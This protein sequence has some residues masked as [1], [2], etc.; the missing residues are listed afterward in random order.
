[1]P[2]RQ[3]AGSGTSARLPALMRGATRSTAMYAAANGHSARCA[4]AWVNHR[5]GSLY[6]AVAHASR[7]AAS[8]CCNAAGIKRMYAFSIIAIE[9][10]VC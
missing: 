9:V 7:T 6:H 4:S 3:F 2:A 8:F 1:M 5:A 10:P